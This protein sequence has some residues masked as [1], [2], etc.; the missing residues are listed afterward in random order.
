[1]AFPQVE[2]IAR[3]GRATAAAVQ[4]INLPAGISTG[5][6]LLMFINRDGGGSEISTPA[7]WTALHS[8]MTNNCARAVFYKEAVGSEGAS[9]SVTLGLSAACAAIVYRVSAWNAVEIDFTAYAIQQVANPPSLS[10]AWGAADT[11]WLC[12]SLAVDDDGT[13]TTGSSGFTNKQEQTAGA[14]TNASATVTVMEREENTATQDPNSFNFSEVEGIIAFTVAI[15]PG[16]KGA[17]G[18]SILASELVA[19]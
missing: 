13:T 7:G 12:G 4:S 9:V 6:L 14:G 1:M 15:E 18:G 11:L 2:A 19:A 16:S 8:T 17:G 5:Q 10:P 3:T